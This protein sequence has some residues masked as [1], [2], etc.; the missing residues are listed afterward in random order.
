MGLLAAGAGAA[1]E[2]RGVFHAL[3]LV[4]AGLATCSL[5]AAIAGM[6]TGATGARTGTVLRAIAVD[7]IAAARALNVAAR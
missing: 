3:A 4:F 5:V 7:C 6:V 2:N 1:Q